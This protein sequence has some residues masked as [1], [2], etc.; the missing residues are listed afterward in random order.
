MKRLYGAAC[1]LF[2]LQTVSSV[3]VPAGVKRNDSPVIGVLAQEVSAPTPGKNAYIAASYVKYLESA[4]ARVVPVMIKKSEEEYIKLFKSINGILFP[5]GGASIVSSG[6]AKAAGIFYR[7]ALEANLKGDYFPV[8]GTC[9]GFELLTFLTSQ[10]LLLSHTNTTG[11]ALP[12]D[13]T[14][15]SKDSRMF[16]DFPDDLITSLAKEPLTENS[17]RWSITTESFNKSEKLKKFYRILS[18][19]TDGQKE[20]VSTVEA[21]DFPIYGTQW[22]PEKNAFEWTRPYI[23]HTPSAIKTTFYTA[24]FFVN[25]AKK[26]LHS[27]SSQEEEQKALIYNY[28]PKYTGKRSSFEQIYY[29]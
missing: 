14:K 18:T 20:F 21:Y 24:Y 9:L 2:L 12:L 8:W 1:F 13:F 10:K 25:E 17:H 28:S 29:F 11:V 3:V 15:E 16:K 6:Y 7:L 19:N 27:F 5:G 23:P 22:H 4:G 26:S